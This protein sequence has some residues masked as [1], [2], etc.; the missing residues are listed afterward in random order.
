MKKKT[1]EKGDA[2]LGTPRPSPLTRPSEE[3][4]GKAGKV[5]GSRTS[6]EVPAEGKVGEAGE[7]KSLKGEKTFK[8]ER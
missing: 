6:E 1:N 2:H 7:A 5:E 4:E 8:R 3:R